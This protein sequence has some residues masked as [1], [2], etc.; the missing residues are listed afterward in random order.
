M[1]TFSHT[2]EDG[3]TV[4]VHRNGD[5]SGDAMVTVEAAGAKNGDPL[6]VD[7]EVPCEALVAFS[8]EVVRKLVARSIEG[9][10]Q[11]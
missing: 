8:G 6:L 10:L 5:F 3:R 11:P 7:V 9:S 2:T 4:R 1:I